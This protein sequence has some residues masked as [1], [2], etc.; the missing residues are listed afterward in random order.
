MG[1]DITFDLLIR[2]SVKHDRKI[3]FLKENFINFL[4]D[5]VFVNIRILFIIYVNDNHINR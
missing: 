1:L 2:P 3:S 5:I 4:F